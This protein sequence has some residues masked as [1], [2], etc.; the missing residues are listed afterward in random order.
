MSKRPPASPSSGRH[1]PARRGMIGALLYGRNVNRPAKSKA[2][3]GL[4]I[5][6]FTLIYAVIATR[7]VMFAVAQDPN[8]GRRAR[9]SVARAAHTPWAG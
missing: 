1:V 6:V 3:V 2:R 7:L 5:A 9:S 8:A 4:A